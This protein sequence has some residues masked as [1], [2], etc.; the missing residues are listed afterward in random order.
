MKIKGKKKIHKQEYE[1][2]GKKKVF[3][4]KNVKIK[5]NKEDSPLTLKGSENIRTIWNYE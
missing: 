5:D 3:T 4:N 1:N 2:K